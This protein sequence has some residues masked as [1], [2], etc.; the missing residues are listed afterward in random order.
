MVGARTV[1]GDSEGGR[2]ERR[3]SYKR[4]GIGAT[5]DGA[6]VSGAH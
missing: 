2:H 3:S 6:D 4:S 1:D 5:T